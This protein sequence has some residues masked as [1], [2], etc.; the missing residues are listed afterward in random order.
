MFMYLALFDSSYDPL[1]PQHS[2]GIDTYT[3]HQSKE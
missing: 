3:E 1:H 2:P